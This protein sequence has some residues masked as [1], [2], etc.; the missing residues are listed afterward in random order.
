MQCARTPGAPLTGPLAAQL[1]RV[2]ALEGM[3]YVVGGGGGGGGV[4]KF[5]PLIVLARQD[6]L[7]TRGLVAGLDGWQAS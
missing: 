3:E 2:T 6:K 7:A 5:S 1:R 4:K